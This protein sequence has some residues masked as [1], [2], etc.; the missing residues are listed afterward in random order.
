MMND[1]IIDLSEY[2]TEL[3]Q[4]KADVEQLQEKAE[5]DLIVG[6]DPC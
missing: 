3:E 1:K 2:R 5:R 4:I 6:L